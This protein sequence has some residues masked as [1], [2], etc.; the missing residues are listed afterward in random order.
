MF[1]LKFKLKFKFKRFYLSFI[2]DTRFLSI[3]SASFCKTAHADL[4]LKPALICMFKL[5][6]HALISLSEIRNLL[7]LSFS[8]PAP[9]NSLKFKETDPEDRMSCSAY[10]LLAN[11]FAGLSKILTTSAAKFINLSSKS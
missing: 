11:I 6:L 4:L 9:A 8:V 10:Y 7:T 1:K 3:Y 2:I 5:L